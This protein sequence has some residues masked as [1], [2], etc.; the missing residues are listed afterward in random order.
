[1]QV[2]ALVVA[3]VALVA[4]AVGLGF[5]M[6]GG[7]GLPLTITKP[8]GGTISGRGINCGSGGSDCSTTFSRNEGVDLKAE[9]DAGFM[10][11][12][13]TGDCRQGG[14]T[15]MIAART[16][17]ATFTKIPVEAATP[18]VTLTIDP[19]KGGTVIGAGIT[20]GTM[21]TEC[22]V[23]H[24]QGKLITLKAL[25][26]P[27][28]TFKG[29]TGEGC[30]RSGETMMNR[31]RTCGA[32]FVKDASAGG[33]N[34]AGGGGGGPNVIPGPSN[35]R[36]TSPRGTGRGSGG[37]GG[38]ATPGYDPSATAGTIK[39]AEPSTPGGPDKPLPPPPTAEGIAKDEIKELL[40][41]YEAAWESLDVGQIQRLY[42]AAPVSGL[43]H[44]FSQF[45]SLDYNYEG[46][47]EFVDLDPG[48]GT[49]TVKV[50]STLKPEYKGPKEK[51]QNLN[52]LFT[53]RRHDGVWKFQDVK[54]TP[55]K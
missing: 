34:I 20:C 50:G 48:L 17:G 5:W 13:F 44:A 8:E 37:S 6:W 35:G 54:S 45:K 4:G 31:P 47:P 2:A 26:D 1:M 42:P 19:P 49:A 15:V 27:T 11:G 18:M 10:F 52:N 51:P 38:T 23:E 36:G 12:G 53:L 55:K 7:S 39:V 16:C 43:K 29:W 32:M 9:P 14:R 46:E 41:A 25:A 3:A 28:F 30:A 24:A 22:S 40:K 33:G 21:G